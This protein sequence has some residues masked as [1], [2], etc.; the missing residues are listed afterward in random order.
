MQ[1]RSRSDLPEERDKVAMAPSNFA[2]IDTLCNEVLTSIELS[3]MKLLNWGFIDILSDLQTQLP[4]I[5]AQL[6]SPGRE[7]WLTAQ[8]R[9]IT[10]NHVLRNLINRR[11]VLPAKSSD[12]VL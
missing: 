10:H 5:L 6:P 7:L 8:Q 4:T 3:E 2:N 12:R 11:L 1:V 9:G